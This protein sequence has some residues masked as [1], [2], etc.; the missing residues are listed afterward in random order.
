MKILLVHNTYQQSGGEDVVF[1]QERRMLER[2]GHRV[3]AYSRSNHEI[4]KLSI[5]GQLGIAQR[6]IWASKTRREFDDLL[7][8]ENP[9]V[10]HIHNTFMVIS[11]SIYSA[12]RARNIPVVQTLHNF[13]L[14]CP[15]AYFYRDGKVCEE[16]MD[17]GLL[18]SIRYGCYRDSKAATATVALMLAA[19]RML[20][21]W[22]DSVDCYI[23]LTK[24]S[25]EKFIAAGFPA[26]KIVVKPN[27]LDTDPGCGEQAGDYALFVGRLSPEKGMSTLLEAWKKLPQG[28][29]LHVVGEGDENRGLLAEARQHGLSNITFRGPLSRQETIAALKNARFLIMPSLWYETFGMVIVEAFACGVPVLC[30]KLGAME[31]I[32]R[33]QHTGLHFAPGDPADLAQK[34]EWAWRHPSELAAMGREARREYE[35]FYTADRNYGMLLEIYEQVVRSR[36]HSKKIHGAGPMIPVGLKRGTATDASPLNFISNA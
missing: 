15:S 7:A 8:R 21:T 31:E 16:C 36:A 23:A 27:F 33:N 12:C 19:H 2:A 5:L 35:T 6:T 1:D 34:V 4:G 14:L 28:Y 24:F 20:R 10:V 17:H 22:D 18:R 13:R 32:V 9:D 3:I 29:Q 11:P 25:R 30:S 26:E